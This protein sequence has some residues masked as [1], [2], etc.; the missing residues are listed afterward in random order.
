MTCGEIMPTETEISTEAS[1][2]ALCLTVINP[3]FPDLYPSSDF[4]TSDS[5]LSPVLSSSLTVHP[6]KPPDKSISSTKIS[7]ANVDLSRVSLNLSVLLFE[8]T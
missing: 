3:S 2:T 6:S 1:V 7:E 5:I 8:Y 4:I